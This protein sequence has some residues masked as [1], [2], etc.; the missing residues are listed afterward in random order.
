M[1][2]TQ[3]AR[4]PGA[5]DSRF[6]LTTTSFREQVMSNLQGTKVSRRCRICDKHFLTTAY[7]LSV[8][9]GLFCSRSC[10][11]KGRERK[12]PKSVRD[13]YYS[14][15]STRH[16]SECW[17][18]LHAKNEGG[19]GLIQ[20]GRTS[21]F[22]HRVSWILHRGRIPEGMC[23]LHRCD[24]PE[25]TNP[26]HLFLGTHADNMRDM[27][28]KGRGRSAI[29]EESS[30]AKLTEK[31]VKEIRAKRQEHGRKYKHL[32]KEYGVSDVAIRAVCIGRTWR[33]V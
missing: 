17:R 19:Y 13:R 18:W 2:N 24:N 8:G 5:Y 16:D 7:R 23:V 10:S 28:E 20:I 21:R 31:M 12:K 27:K 30:A 32:A 11:D 15:I 9:R 14:M 3:I 33:H 22:A 25:C 1:Y 6:P 26:K 4:E 29:G